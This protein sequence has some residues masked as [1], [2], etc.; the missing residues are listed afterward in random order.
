M[1]EQRRVNW[2]CHFSFV[3]TCR[4]SAEDGRRDGERRLDASVWDS[5]RRRDTE[6]IDSLLAVRWRIMGAAH[7]KKNQERKYKAD[8]I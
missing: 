2:A 8:F 4:R 1:T 3:F 5:D 7:Q 6:Q